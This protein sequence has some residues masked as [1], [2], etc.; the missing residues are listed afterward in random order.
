MKKVLL[1]AHKIRFFVQF[2]LNDIK[3]L[4]ELG[5]EVHVASNYKSEEM[6]VDSYDKLTS[7]NV[8]VH[9]VDF[10]RSPLHF[11][12]NKKALNQLTDIIRTNGYE[13]I[14]CHTPV[15][16]VLARIAGKQT[17]IKVIYTAHGFHFYKGAPLKNWLLFY[18]V[19]WLCAHWTDTLITINK[20]DYALAQKHMHAKKVEYIPGVGLDIDKFKNCSVDRAENRKELGIGEEDIAILSVGELNDN[21]NHQVVINA[22]AKLQNNKLHYLIAGQ[23]ENKDKLIKLANDLGL[24]KNVHLLGYRS[25]INELCKS[26]DIYVLPS[27]REGL[28]VS[29]MEAMASGLPCVASEIRGNT[30]LIDE[31]GGELFNPHDVDDCK[32]AIET[33]LSKDLNKLGNYNQ[34]KINQFDKITVI[35]E[36]KKIYYEIGEK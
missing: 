31:D 13:F 8:K 33:V 32:N 34:E 18:P 30:D 9:Q 12:K 6:I 26:A 23:G 14:H 21:K 10:E 16:G 19:E 11:I 5:D 36:M 17:K 4:Q 1:V 15:G 20:E 3:L 27:I 24:A 25:D 29:L 22:L 7:M 28:N 35:E 2:E